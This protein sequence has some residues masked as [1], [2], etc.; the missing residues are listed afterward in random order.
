M[1]GHIDWGPNTSL[2]TGQAVIDSMFPQ[3]AMMKIATEKQMLMDAAMQCGLQTLARPLG[4]RSQGLQ[5]MEAG[6]D[7]CARGQPPADAALHPT[8]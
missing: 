2:Y 5:H 6:P 3:S 4:V 1:Q 7:W 8:K